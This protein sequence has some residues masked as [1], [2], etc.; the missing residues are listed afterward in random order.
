MTEQAKIVVRG[1]GDGGHDIDE[2]ILKAGDG[3]VFHLECM[4]HTHYW[5]G[6][7]LPDGRRVSFNIGH[8]GDSTRVT[9]RAQDDERTAE[10]MAGDGH[11]PGDWTAWE[12][13]TGGDK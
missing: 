7:Y 4:D 6:V 10:E 5:F 8:F 3:S 12:S 2:V 11:S 13:D 9:C 1:F